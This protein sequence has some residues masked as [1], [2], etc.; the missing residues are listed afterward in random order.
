LDENNEESE[1]T[2]QERY[3]ALLVDIVR[4]FPGFTIEEKQDSA[5]MKFLDVLLRIITLNMMRNF[6]TYYFTIVDE[7]LYVPA[8]KWEKL[9]IASRIGLLRHERV[10]MRQRRRYGKL[11]YKLLFLLLPAPTIFAYYRM[12]FE[13]EAYMESVRAMA[14]L[15]GDEVAYSTENRDWVIKQFTSPAYFWMWPWKKSLRRRWDESIDV[16]RKAEPRP[17]RVSGTYPTEQEGR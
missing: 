11:W 12:K 1:M 15:R 13:W 10:H 16:M 5:Y 17:V 3:E 7:T 6:M 2:L 8:E 9:S 14:E 4:E